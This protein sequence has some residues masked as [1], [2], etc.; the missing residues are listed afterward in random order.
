MKIVALSGYSRSGKD[1]VG[2]ILVDHWGAERRAL[3]DPIRAVL[4][5]MDLWLH[6]G[7][8]LNNLLNDHGWDWVK[9]HYSEAVD[10]MIGL[11]N[12]MRRHVNPDVWIPAMFK[13]PQPEL[14]VVTDVRYPNEM[15]ALVRAGAISWRIEREGCQPRGMDSFL[16]DYKFTSY[17]ENNGTLEELAEKVERLALEWLV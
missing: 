5:E 8:K 1:T 16:D 10:W 11:G 9:A 17:I 2:K 3:A 13:D 15:N 7:V 12:G 4:M 6:D 14:L